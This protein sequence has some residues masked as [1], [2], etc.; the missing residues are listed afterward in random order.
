M[1]DER[2]AD[3]VLSADVSN[4]EQGVRTAE[5]QTLSL[6]G[7]VGKLTEGIARLNNAAGRNIQLVGAGTL[8]GLV[9]ATAAAAKFDSQLSQIQANSVMTGRSVDTAKRAVNDLRG[10]FSVATSDAVGLVTQLNKMGQGGRPVQ[11]IA[12][13]IVKLSAVTGESQS[14]MLG[15]VQLQRQMGTE[16]VKNT[17]NYAASLANLSEKAG[18]SADGVLQFSQ[19]IAPISQMAGM[20][21]KEVMGFSTA[22]NKSGQE[23]TL[24]AM[25]Y[26]KMISDMTR[27]VQF[28]GPELQTYA[29][30]LGT[31]TKGLREMSASQAGMKLLKTIG[32][33]GP[34][35]QQI[36]GQLG[37]EGQ[38]TQRA[39]A[40]VSQTGDLEQMMGL[41]NEP[42][43][44]KKFEEAAEEALNGL[45]DSLGIFTNNITRLTQAL[46]AGLLPAME[47]LAK[48]LANITGAAATGME[49]L[50]NIPGV[51][52]ALGGASLIGGGTIVRGAGVLMAGAGLRMLTNSSLRAGWTSAR[53]NVK[54]TPQWIRNFSMA[55]NLEWVDD[56]GRPQRGDPRVGTT[57]RALFDVGERA[58]SWLGT[59]Q[60]R[61]VRAGASWARRNII[62]GASRAGGYGI[63]GASYMARANLMPLHPDRLYDIAN[64]DQMGGGT[65]PLSQ[66]AGQ[67]TRARARAAYNT[68]STGRYQQDASRTRLRETWRAWRGDATPG[69]AGAVG[70][71]KDMK[72]LSEAT[73]NLT[74]DQRSHSTVLRSLITESGRYGVGLG[75]ATVG[76]G[77]LTQ[78]AA[79]AMAQ[80]LW[81]GIKSV[82]S[83][84]LGMIGGGVGAGVLAAGWM[85]TEFMR[86]RQRQREML[87]QNDEDLSGI[88]V[89]R[90]SL[91][92][93][94]E[95]TK[96]F[97]D[98]VNQA[99]GEIDG[100][101]PPGDGQALTTQ[102]L[103]Y[104]RSPDYKFTNPAFKNMTEEQIRTWGSV[105]L[106]GAQSEVRGAF[107][108]DALANLGDLGTV[109]SMLEGG[110]R[111]DLSARFADHSKWG[112]KD[113]GFLARWGE[114]ILGFQSQATTDRSM[115]MADE[116]SR[117]ISLAPDQDKMAVAMGG[118][119]E[120]LAGTRH[121]KNAIHGRDFTKQKANVRALAGELGLS[122]EETTDLWRRFVTFSDNPNYRNLDDNEF[123]AE[124]LHGLG[125]DPDS[126]LGEYL[127]AAAPGGTVDDYRNLPGMPSADG[128]G[129]RPF[130]EWG[131]SRVVDRLMGT[132][133]GQQ[134]MQP[135]P[136]KQTWHPDPGIGIPWG[137]GPT[138]RAN[139]SAQYEEATGELPNRIQKQIQEAM[140][141]PHD[142]WRQQNAAWTLGTE[143]VDLFNGDFASHQQALINFRDAINS[144]SDPLWQLAQA[145]IA[146]SR[147]REKEVLEDRPRAETIAVD[148][149][150]YERAKKAWEKMNLDVPVDDKSTQ[151][152]EEFLSGHNQ[153]QSNRREVRSRAI[154]I[155]QSDRELTI[156]QE[157]QRED[158]ALQK[159][160]AQEDFDLSREYAS[161]DF[162][163]SK[164][165]R[166]EARDRQLERTWR[167]FNLSRERGE[168]D[169]NLQRARAVESYDRQ[170]SRTLRDYNIARERAQ[171]EFSLSRERQEENYERQLKRTWRDYNISRERAENDFYRQRERGIFDFN[172]QRLRQEEDYNHQI[173]LM[174]EA[175]AKQVYNIYERVAVARTLSGENLVRNL[176]DQARRL[177]EQQA[178]LAKAREMGLSD[179]AIRMLGLNEATGAQ[180]LQRLMTELTPEMIA[181]LNAQITE[182][183]GLA[184]DLMSDPAN[185]QYAEMQRQYEL[186]RERAQ[187]DFKRSMER[188]AEDF[189]RMRDQQAED[190]LRSL[191]DQAQ[192][193]QI[194]LSQSH[195]DFQRMRSQQQT[196]FNQNLTDQRLEFN[197]S[198]AQS[199]EDFDTM[200]QRQWTD[201]MTAL[202]DQAE[203]YDIQTEEMQFQF[204]QSM[205][206]QLAAFILAAERNQAALDLMQ[207][208]ARDSFFRNNEEIS[209]ELTALWVEAALKLEGEAQRSFVDMGLALGTQ[210]SEIVRIAEELGVEMT[211]VFE[212]LGINTVLIGSTNQG[213]AD[214]TKYAARA[215]GGP[216][217]G[218][219]PHKKADNILIRA[220]AGEFM[221]PVDSVD[222]YGP[223]VMEGMRQRKI[224]KEVFQ[225][226][227]TGG[228]ITGWDQAQRELQPSLISLG[229]ELQKQGYQVG[230]HPLFGGVHP[231]AHMPTSKGGLHYIGHAL[232]INY[233][234]YGQSVE[235][236]MIDNLVK[237]V[238][239]LGLGYIWRS[240][241]HYGHI[242]VDTSRHRQLNG[243]RT[244]MG[245]P[246]GG[247]LSSFETDSK[248]GISYLKDV[249]EELKKKKSFQYWEEIMDTQKPTWSRYRNDGLA[250]G[251]AMV[252]YK[253]LMEGLGDTGGEGN[254]PF[255][256]PGGVERWRTT[257]ERALRLMS[258]PLS[259]AD[260]TLRRMNQESSGNPRAINLWDSNARAGTPS[261][262]L[263]QV[264]DPT[265]RAYAVDGYDRD[266][267]DPMSNI[268]ASM[269]YALGRYGGLYKAYSRIGGY[270]DGGLIGWHGEGAI[271]TGPRQ[272]GVGERGPEMV[273]PLYGRGVEFLSAL[274]KRNQGPDWRE[275]FVRRDGVPEVSKQI[276]YNST[277]DQSTNFNGNITVQAQDPE[278]MARKLAARKRQQALIGRR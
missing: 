43:S 192:D 257:V 115:G 190:F 73:K 137:A 146:F 270:A 15:L 86:S 269:S 166:D 51:A 244:Y 245:G 253:T 273:L 93:A 149:R 241:N 238:E 35:G 267:W 83:S 102:D 1:A 177:A 240:A 256:V 138:I 21:M 39:I 33:E 229:R 171:Y 6:L 120:A 175:T 78:Q 249:F 239:A 117:L 158:F 275:T 109:A 277:Y 9:G 49:K 250:L 18:V 163:R 77:I 5:T 14:S 65:D 247:T 200:R 268:L 211:E 123:A 217:P 107:A 260:V 179:E 156:G 88:G 22:F 52:G 206:R 53:G 266:I 82:G 87:T 278:E 133:L 262:G 167:D 164:R 194:A 246:M 144:A 74:K 64:R 186:Q 98:A 274:M 208:R 54:D 254:E 16:G 233:D 75:K 37:L 228:L 197:I 111:P 242:H 47:G 221:Q 89:Y 112:V 38:R 148:T 181:Q 68:W 272:I 193:F 182:R 105:N 101:G 210:K 48:G 142:L 204:D 130:S 114:Q 205:D 199:A 69:A 2:R 108:Y 139:Y 214:K 10:S 110:E 57:Q 230:E 140:D 160:Y 172:L 96:G 227:A 150:E 271:F 157:Q 202:D 79:G 152:F 4:Y 94:A 176:E 189:Q 134:I 8:A 131:G 169:F 91:G 223:D 17:Q 66:A 84:A 124:F 126:K 178:N 132:G 27:A 187:E 219:S 42:G 20:G 236:R 25:S 125:R 56:M 215:E 28:G 24:A 67:E 26:T 201:F 135:Y 153:M 72:G 263:M 128:N 222:Y 276:V 185:R 248:S 255:T 92:L 237:R 196:D 58:G 191:A 213:S 259:L 145:A 103:D 40:A 195:E 76:A 170:L 99:R 203:E 12:S 100:G 161:T 147:Q 104:A 71:S 23:G 174:A 59:Y 261:K 50:G 180:Q 95:A 251:G 19:A 226:Y 235:N 154:G 41:T 252:A 119:G 224:P 143:G 184:G 13:E 151:A 81:R 55:R 7:A 218:S 61:D 129:V 45:N 29:N 63:W 198:M 155:I 97:A 118:L 60:G 127:R 32:E 106:P 173:V 168:Y 162:T 265:F 216:I 243:V 31:T 231:T 207:E 122:E 136:E 46:G 116:Y 258:Q 220:T 188:S 121:V 232:D 165:L 141:N 34:R 159:Q 44:R 90:T 36:L 30:I 85:G 11:E 264:I 62:G 234:G 225:G 209:G 212:M 70:I 3:V 113:Q 183:T 80:P